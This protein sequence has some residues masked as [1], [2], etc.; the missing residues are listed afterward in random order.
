MYQCLPAGHGA[1][2]HLDRLVSVRGPVR[3]LEAVGAAG[4][5]LCRATDG[6]QHHSG[7]HRHDQGKDAT[8]GKRS[9]EVHNAS[10]EGEPLIGPVPTDCK[11]PLISA[12][13]SRG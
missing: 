11:A 1:D 8:N 10:E 6:H 9:V 4:S 2:L 5:S 12:Y 7:E 3:V 13:L